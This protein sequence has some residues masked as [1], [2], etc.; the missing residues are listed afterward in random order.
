MITNSVPRLTPVSQCDIP[1]HIGPCSDIN[2]L[3]DGRSIWLTSGKKRFARNDSEL[4]VVMEHVV[5]HKIKNHI[6]KQRGNQT[7]GQ[8]LDLLASGSGGNTCGKFS[9]IDSQEFSQHFEAEAD[10]V[11]I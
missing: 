10:N 8:I 1:Y 4:S 7:M 6:D 3:V 9:D 2:V 5:T 11:R